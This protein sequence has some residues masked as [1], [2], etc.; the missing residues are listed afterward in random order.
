MTHAENTDFHDL[1]RYIAT[2]RVSGLAMSPDGRRLITTVATLDEKSTGHTTALWEIDPTGHLPAARLTQGPDSASAPTFDGS[3]ALWFIRKSAPGP[4]ENPTAAVWRLPTVGEA[5]RVVARPG[6]VNSLVTA[7]AADT[8]LALADVLGGSAE[9]DHA[10]RAK[11]KTA[12]VSAILHDRYPVRLWDSDLGPGRP[13]LFDLAPSGELAAVVENP[14]PALREAG[15]G[16]APD[17]SFAITTW[18]VGA[19]QASTRTTLVRIGFGDAGPGERV[20]LLADPDHDF[21]AP[22]VSPDGRRVAFL[23]ESVTTPTDAP[24]ITAHTYDLANGSVTDWATGWDRWPSSVAWSAEGTEL[25]VTADD[26]GRGQ[27][28]VLGDPAVATSSAVRAVTATDH[29]Y[30]DVAVHPDAEHLF[31][32][33]SSPAEPPHVVRV[34]LRSGEVTALRGPVA[35]PELPGT[36]EDLRTEAID[37]TPLRAWLALPHGASDSSPVPLLLWVHGGPLGSWNAWSWR[38]NP[39]IAV[40]AGYAV[41]LPDPALSTGY[42]QNFIRRGWGSWGFEPYTD[43]MAVTDAA[44]A[45]RRIASGRTAIMGGSFGGYMANWIAGHTDRFRAVVTHA[46]LWALDQFGPT[47]DGADYWAREMSPEMAVENSPHLYVADIVTPML[48]IHGDKDYRVPIGEGLRLWYELLSESGLPAADDG[49]T[50]HRFLY[51]PDEN[52]WILKPQNAIIWY[53][54]VL[55]F[56]SQHVLDRPAELPDI[57]G[58]VTI[59]AAQD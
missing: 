47:T 22:T 41:V 50:V 48:V 15:V 30:T 14:G 1:D 57:L 9:A 24:V 43:L 28:F 26:D 18:R 37:G 3:G 39:W 45:D 53:R 59:A 32:L 11:R 31:A 49:S 46:S 27:V 51:F 16:V 40:A 36:L 2:P 17:G 5:Q 44:E 34:D 33:R 7:R 56:L 42:G 21:F 6:G 23:R 8:V 54:V 4:D 12:A 55:A 20:T 52:H 58:D 10:L 35:L 25:I 29:C 19:P 38:W 13:F